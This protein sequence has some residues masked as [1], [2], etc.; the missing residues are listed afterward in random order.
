MG[1][2]SGNARFQGKSGRSYNK[3]I[4]ISDSAGVPVKFDSG[5][6]ANANGDPNVQFDEAVYLADVVIA[7]QTTVTQLSATKNGV[8][9]GDTLFVANQLASVANRPGLAIPLGPYQRFG[10]IQVT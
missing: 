7:A 1:A 10:L 8:P 5:S 9:T 6:G 2:Q 4:Y 3:A